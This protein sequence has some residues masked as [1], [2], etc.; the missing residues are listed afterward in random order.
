MNNRS[1]NGSANSS[2]TSASDQSLRTCIEIPLWTAAGRRVSS[3]N[4]AKYRA[5]PRLNQ[6]RWPV[7]VDEAAASMGEL[8]IERDAEKNRHAEVIVVE[9]RLE[10]GLAVARANQP[11]VMQKK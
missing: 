3:R 11:E 8:V 6:P 10:T 7:S 5:A 9:K 2:S 4:R 1:M